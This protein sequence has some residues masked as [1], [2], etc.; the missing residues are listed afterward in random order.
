M[1]LQAVF[2]GSFW[3]YTKKRVV[4]EVV[5]GLP[6][7]QQGL[8]P[9]EYLSSPDRPLYFQPENVLSLHHKDPETCQVS[10]MCKKLEIAP[11]RDIFIQGFHGYQEDA[12][13]F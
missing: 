7:A 10:L 9:I 8:Q 4:L 12:R 13:I 6:H 3:W 11:E 5:P 1:V 2:R